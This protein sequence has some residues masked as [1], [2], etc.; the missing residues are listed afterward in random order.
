[1]RKGKLTMETNVDHFVLTALPIFHRNKW[2]HHSYV[3]GRMMPATVDSIL[4]CAN[5]TISAL[6]QQP[7]RGDTPTYAT[8]GRVMATAT[9]IDADGY[10]VVLT[11]DI[12]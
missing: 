7:A 10:D 1:M 5:W 11:L 9:N 4:Q 3:A 2:E 8:T 6:K 12:G